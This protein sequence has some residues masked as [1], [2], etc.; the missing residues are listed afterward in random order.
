MH[1][2]LRNVMIKHSGDPVEFA[3]RLVQRRFEDCPF[4]AGAIA[5]GRKCMAAI[6]G[7]DHIKGIY[8]AA[9][10]QPFLLH[11]TSHLAQALGDPDWRV[12]TT[13]KH[14]YATGVP[15]AFKERLPRT[16]AVYERKTRWKRYEDD[17]YILEERKN[18]PSAS[19]AMGSIR[20]QFMEEKKEGR[21][22]HITL[23]EARAKYG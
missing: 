21:M 8:D 6:I 7:A 10:G 23:K 15:V 20:E 11:L 14:S 12:L 16:P 13:S 19:V 22:L 5:E 3:C 18:Y 17:D 2:E 9:S 1:D 4:S